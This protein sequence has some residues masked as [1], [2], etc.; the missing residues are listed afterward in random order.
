MGFDLD[1]D[2]EIG[3]LQS[4][5]EVFFECD[6]Q[7]R[8]ITK[9]RRAGFTRG[10][11]QYAIECL[12]NGE[13]VLWID[14]IQLNLDGYFQLYMLPV[15]NQIPHEYW[16][17]NLSQ[18][19]LTVGGVKLSM[20][21]AERA[22]NIEG[23]AFPHIILNEA[24]IILKGRRGRNL[25]QSS[26]FP[27]I[28]DY[29]SNVY[30]IGTP[31]GRSSMKGEI[32]ETG[33]CLYYE[34]A[35]RGND[36]DTKWKTFNYSSYSNPVLDREAIAQIE[37]EV[38]LALRQQEI[39]GQFM[40]LGG[41]LVFKED[42]FHIIDHPPV[43]Y[44][45]K[46]MSLD[47]AFKKEAHNDYS[48]GVVFLETSNTYYWLD[49]F[50]LKL[51]F[52]ELIEQVVSWYNYHKPDMVLIEDKASGQS[53]IQA[54]KRETRIPILPVKVDTDKLSRTTAITSLFSTGLVKLIR[55]KWNREA[56]DQHCEFNGI[57]DYDDDIVDAVSQV[58]NYSKRSRID[59]KAKSLPRRPHRSQTLQ[60]Y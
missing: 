11:A 34:L 9:G 6:A 21:S 47:T 31:K 56:I 22:E 13:P 44:R 32:S 33:R 10:G 7:F 41:Q 49:T 57:E 50:N 53:L 52:P 15:L 3:Y 26:I 40:D 38:P 42:W 2:L 16:K 60:G 17:Y 25:W 8:V 12:I 37:C 28:M 20:R 24:G 1:L 18:H 5:T 59:Y 58:L 30:F 46:I 29:N 19:E 39:Y 14:T 36:V 27:M 48:A 55:G 54:L 23:F 51:E 4:Q 35:E 45:R 43:D